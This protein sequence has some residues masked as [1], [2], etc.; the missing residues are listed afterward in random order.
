[1]L[2]GPNLRPI[3]SQED[4]DKQM[5]DYFQNLFNNGLGVPVKRE[6]LSMAEGRC[7]QEQGYEDITFSVDFP[8]D[9][10]FST[11]HLESY[12]DSGF[13]ADE[14]NFW[15][16]LV[17]MIPQVSFFPVNYGPVEIL[18]VGCG[19]GL[20]AVGLHAYFGNAV[21]PN[22]GVM[23]NYFGI[24][25]DTEEIKKA[26]A[27]HSDRPDLNFIV[28]DATDLSGHF[29][30]NKEFSV[31]VIRHQNIGGDHEIWSKIIAEAADH[32]VE[33]GILL[34]TSYSCAEHSM[35]EEEVRGMGLVTYLTG[36]NTSSE[37]TIPAPAEAQGILSRD[38][39]VG[40]YGLPAP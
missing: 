29:E 26:W 36:R 22:E 40:I 19:E 13:L 16:L 27:Y 2:I 28:A 39:Y 7:E 34:I 31:V 6:L 18:D 3:T 14:I 17:G 8:K 20:D 37:L 35:M 5:A 15:N 25:I 4:F 32:L 1:M 30:T 33:G 10:P 24:D 38:K 9:R 21:Y 12:G 23:V 11:T